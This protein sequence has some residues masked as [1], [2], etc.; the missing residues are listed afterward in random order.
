MAK[1][2]RSD[3]DRTGRG[4]RE[5]RR[6]R[7]GGPRARLFVALDLPQPARTAIA[8]WRDRAIAGRPELRSVAPDALHVTL[9]F[10]GWRPESETPR[11]AELVSAAGSG[12]SAPRLEPGEV[13]AL[14][15]RRPRLFALGLRDEAD[16]ASSVQAAVSGALAG[17]NLYEPEARPFW[18]HVTLAR[19][20]RGARSGA[21]EPEPPPAERFTA[22]DLTLYRSTLRPQGALYEALGRTRLR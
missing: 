3:T 12:C 8:G 10:L 21:L 19:V 5:G 7:P 17:A 6:G 14:P 18:P 20:R 15:S 2:H 11:I 1:T 16:A 4:P 9:C 13:V 22:R